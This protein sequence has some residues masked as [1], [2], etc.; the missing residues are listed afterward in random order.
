MV[1]H[2]GCGMT[3][4][5]CERLLQKALERG[6]SKETLEML[7]HSGINLQR[8]LTGFDSPQDGVRQSVGL[9]RH[10]PLLPKGVPVHGMMISPETGELE[11]LEDGYATRA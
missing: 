10:H 8:W 9:I 11:L 2:Y 5:S 7:E 1:G 4:L 6:V 3:G